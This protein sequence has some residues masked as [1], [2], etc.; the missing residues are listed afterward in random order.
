MLTGA[1]RTTGHYSC[2][3]SSDGTFGPGQRLRPDAPQLTGFRCTSGIHPIA[4]EEAACPMC[5]AIATGAQAAKRRHHY[6]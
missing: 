4:S 3:L 2:H 5:A 1:P 6:R